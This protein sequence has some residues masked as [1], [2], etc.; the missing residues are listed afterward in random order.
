MFVFKVDCEVSTVWI[1]LEH[2]KVLSSRSFWVL[3]EKKM[4]KQRD[5]RL[6]TPVTLRMVIPSIPKR[7]KEKSL[8]EEDLRRM[9]CNMLME[10]S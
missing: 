1:E 5:I 2:R 10:R 6:L 9:G 8:L 3:R 4:A 7:E